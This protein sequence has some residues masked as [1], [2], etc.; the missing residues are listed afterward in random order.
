METTFFITQQEIDMLMHE[1][2]LELSECIK[3]KFIKDLAKCGGNLIVN[4]KLT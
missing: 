2:K 3:E 1:G 4:L